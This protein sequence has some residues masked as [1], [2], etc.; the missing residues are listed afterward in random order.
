MR[1]F[2]V[3]AL[4]LAVTMAARATPSM[5]LQHMLHPKGVTPAKHMNR[6]TNSIDSE[7]LIPDF[8]CSLRYL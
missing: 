6:L 2:I 3:I 7:Q 4:V 1:S 5:L 8:T